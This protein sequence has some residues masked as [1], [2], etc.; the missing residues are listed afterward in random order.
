MKGQ[1]ITI[2]CIKVSEQEK[3]NRSIP[4]EGDVEERY[5]QNNR[6]QIAI[7]P[8]TAHRAQNDYLSDDK[9]PERERGKYLPPVH[10]S[11]KTQFFCQKR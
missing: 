9:L 3:T 2:G 4:C 11:P 7:A 5:Y 8:V 1:R 6:R 10:P